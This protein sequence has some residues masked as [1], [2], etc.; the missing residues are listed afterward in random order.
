MM[1][2]RHLSTEFEPALGH[3]TPKADPAERRAANP[4]ARADDLEALRDSVAFEPALAPHGDPQ[5]WSQWLA[6]RRTRCTPQGDLAVTTLAAVLGGPVA[7]VGAFLAGSPGILQVAY[8]VVFGPVVEELLK[9]SGMTFLLEKKPWRVFAAWQFIY[10][11][12]V[13]GLTFAA[14]ENVIYIYV[15]APA[16]GIADIERLAAFRWT[17]CTALHVGC[18]TIAS[19]GLIRAWRRQLSAGGPVDLAAA[20]PF[21]TTAM[22]IHGLYNLSA[23]FFAGWFE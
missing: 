12:V 23:I 17:V 13:A 11:A 5:R 6:E 18:A 10:C 22:V 19:L 8:L 7:V 16:Q 9:Q 14:I 2:K 1:K 20:L 3:G 15:Y 4:T 21:F